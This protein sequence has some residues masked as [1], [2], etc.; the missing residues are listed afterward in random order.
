MLPEGRGI[1]QQI[2]RGINTKL[3]E[4]QP[5][6]LELDPPDIQT[7]IEWLPDREKPEFLAIAA[8]FNRFAVDSTLRFTASQ[9]DVEG[10]EGWT[11][12]V[13]GGLTIR[14]HHVRAEVIERLAA[15]DEVVGSEVLKADLQTIDQTRKGKTTA[16]RR[17]EGADQSYQSLSHQ[18]KQT[19]RLV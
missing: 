18:G 17:T 19:G 3:L 5:P 11:I 7:G 6:Y 1:G 8:R 13:V 4:N 9:T 15:W 12:A 2:V 14:R 16:G 10:M